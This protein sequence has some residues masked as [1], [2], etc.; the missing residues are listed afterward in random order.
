MH[1]RSISAAR[2][3]DLAWCGEYR[4]IRAVR[5]RNARLYI[6][7]QLQQMHQSLPVVRSFY[8]PTYVSLSQVNLRLTCYSR[9]IH[10]CARQRYISSILC[11]HLSTYSIY[12]LQCSRD[13]TLLVISVYRIQGKWGQQTTNGLLTRDRC[14]T[15]TNMQ[16][17]LGIFY[18]PSAIMAC[19]PHVMP[20]TC[21]FL[22]SHL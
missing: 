16:P 1:V 21:L 4:L 15:S 2:L 18:S 11:T 8:R 12:V 6:Q 7:V 9:C 17:C 22:Q 19:R 10:M 20:G 13:L 14:G 3:S 5:Q